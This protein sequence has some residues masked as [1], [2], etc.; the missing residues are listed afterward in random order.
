[1]KKSK[2]KLLAYALIP[3]IGL[4]ILGFN[5]ASAHGLFSNGFGFGSTATPQ[6]IAD[7]QQNMFR[8]EATLLGI[9]VE[10]VKN[11]WAEGKSLSQL[12]QEKG[13]TATQLQQKM[14]DMMTEQLKTQL[15]TLVDKGIISQEQADKRLQFMQDKISKNKNGKRFLKGFHGYGG[16]MGMMR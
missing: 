15:K 6:E 13:I 11:A 2:S 3:A 4:G 7:S 10:D 12:A 9:G 5:A 16:M 14:K 1:M 8:S